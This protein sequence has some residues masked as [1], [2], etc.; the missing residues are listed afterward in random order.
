MKL[1]RLNIV[2]HAILLLSIGQYKYVGEIKK[3]EIINVAVE[4]AK[5]YL[6]SATDGALNNTTI[7]SGQNVSATGRGGNAQTPKKSLVGTLK[8]VVAGGTKNSAASNL[9]NIGMMYAAGQ[10][11]RT[12]ENTA[13]RD[14][15]KK[16]LDRFKA[17]Y[18]E[19]LANGTAQQGDPYYE[20]VIS[21]LQKKYDTFDSIIKD[22]VQQ[23]ATYQ[24]A[25]LAAQSASE[26]VEKAKELNPVPGLFGNMLVDAG[27]SMVQVAADAVG[28]AALAPILGPE[29]MV[30]FV[31]RSFGSGA[32]HARLDGADTLGEQAAYGSLIALKEYITEKMFNVALPYSKVY[33][34]GKV[35]DIL[36]EAAGKF[37][38]KLVKNE[39]ARNAITK[40]SLSTITEAIEEAA[41]AAE[42]E[43]FSIEIFLLSFMLFSFISK[44]ELCN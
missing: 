27:T 22:E 15:Y 25:D 34:K 12:A 2:A 35:D 44:S 40:L 6:P 1:S 30:P 16:E 11:A 26:N 19:E 29:T 38:G 9:N 28:K 24:A 14:Q 23:K 10:E 37:I 20:S 7:Q 41:D 17:A 33:G 42:E 13:Q 21:D 36:E 32:Q 3:A 39:T 5:K 43:F 18:A 31:A 4:L 8:N